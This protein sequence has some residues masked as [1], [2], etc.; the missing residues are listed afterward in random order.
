MS[1]NALVDASRISTVCD[2]PALSQ[3]M[4]YKAIGWGSPS[5]RVRLMLKDDAA[6]QQ[7]A[8]RSVSDALRS[9]RASRL[10]DSQ[11]QNRLPVGFTCAYAG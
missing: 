2:L 5:V 7:A 6:Y 4:A 1:S 3:S 8:I 9:A 10:V 11:F